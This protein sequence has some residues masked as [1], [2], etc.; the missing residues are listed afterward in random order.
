MQ[1]WLSSSATLLTVSISYQQIDSFT[2][3]INTVLTYAPV[4]L[5][6]S[7]FKHKH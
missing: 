2:E 7:D 1:F 5:K 6:E 3:G 4:K